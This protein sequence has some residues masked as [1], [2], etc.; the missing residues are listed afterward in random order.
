MVTLIMEDREPAARSPGVRF[1]LVPVLGMVFYFI[2]GR[3]WATVTEEKR[4]MQDYFAK[5]QVTLRPF[6]ARNAAAE[7]R[8]RPVWGRVYRAPERHDVP[9]GRPPAW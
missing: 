1:L 3:D 4:S 8:F 9:R 7:R 5:V 2:A 6:F